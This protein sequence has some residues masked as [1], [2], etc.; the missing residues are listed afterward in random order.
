[1]GGGGRGLVFPKRKQ[2]GMYKGGPT[3][4]PSP[5]PCPS[6]RPWARPPLRDACGRLLHSWK[7]G[8]Q[9]WLQGSAIGGCGL[10]SLGSSSPSS[11]PRLPVSK[12]IWSYLKK[13]D[14]EVTWANLFPGELPPDGNMGLVSWKVLPGC[15]RVPRRV[16]SLWMGQGSGTSVLG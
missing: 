7:A 2:L 4:P 16:W 5:L 10:Q 1:M 11:D 14:L 12:A 15:S 8:P 6:Q 9:K 13:P 3:R